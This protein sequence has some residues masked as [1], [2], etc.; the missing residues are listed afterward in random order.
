MR[1]SS[2][3]SAA[4]ET[5]AVS[6]L[7][8]RNGAMFE[9]SGVELLHILSSCFRLGLRQNTTRQQFDCAFVLATLSEVWVI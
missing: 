6:C 7:S 3:R 5:Q 8:R 2:S 1:Y 9:W 4:R